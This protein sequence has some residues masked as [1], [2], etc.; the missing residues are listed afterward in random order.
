MVGEEA[1]VMLGKGKWGGEVEE[2]KE[3]AIEGRMREGETGGAEEER[4]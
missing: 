4:Q 3:G 2:R 1:L